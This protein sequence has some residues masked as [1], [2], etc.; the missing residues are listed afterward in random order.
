MSLAQKGA[1]KPSVENNFPYDF[2]AALHRGDDESALAC[3]R[4]EALPD[5]DVP[6]PR[7]AALM[8]SGEWDSNQKL[9]LVLVESNACSGKVGN[10]DY[11]FCGK[12]ANFCNVAAHVKNSVGP[13][14]RG[15]YISFGRAHGV[16]SS[17]YLPSLDN[18]GPISGILAARLLSSEN[19]FRLTKG[20]WKFVIDSWHAGRVES[21]SVSTNAE[22][23]IVF[24]EHT[25]PKLIDPQPRTSE[26]L[27]TLPSL[28][29]DEELF[30]QT[31]AD[32][33]LDD[34][35]FE[36]VHQ[37]EINEVPALQLTLQIE[38]LLTKQTEQDAKIRALVSQNAYFHQQR[39]AANDQVI[40][41]NAQIEQMRHQ[42]EQQASMSAGILRNLRER[43]VILEAT[44]DRLSPTGAN[45]AENSD[46]PVN[47]AVLDKIEQLD[48]AVFGT[49][50]TFERFKESFI[51]FREKLE[52]GGGVECNGISFTCHRDFMN[53]YAL[54]EPYVDIFLDALAYMHAIRAPVVH[55]DDATKLR[56]L[57]GKAEIATGLEA[58]VLTSFDTILPSILVGSGGRKGDSTLG[59]TYDWLSG[60]LKSYKIWKP[61]G[62]NNGVSHQIT[63]GVNNV[64]KRIAE[65][66]KR[67]MVSEVS[68]LSNGLCQSSANFCNELVRFVNEQQE[69]L[70]SNTAYSED[71]IWVMQLECIQRIVEELSEAR[72]AYSDAGRES[73]GNYIWGMLMSYKVQQR[74]MDNHFKD[75]PALTGVLVRRI[76]LQG[77]DSS[78]KKQLAKI[79]TTASNLESYKQNNNGEIRKLKDELAKLKDELSKLKK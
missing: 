48:S 61:V 41:V 51:E 13:I 25:Q 33:P 30:L 5:G 79:D 56:E 8:Q 60:Y 31:N 9:S 74:Y 42:S 4:S 68:L 50:G 7:A 17:P 47:Q 38:E 58:A 62:S 43:F 52:S 64:S 12:P 27:H 3:L 34:R 67:K 63:T 49:G 28:T 39:N 1:S 22:Q 35:P 19:P 40:A 65:L 71:Q 46:I 75:D 23:E 66:R 20:Q 15:W 29:T 21:L 16:L 76:L 18:G 32:Q 54:H 14:Q 36:T 59:G 6:S 57:Q 53:W 72:E 55:S 2:F 26:K 24:E 73:R 45:T 69:E 44:V 37:D 77:Q 11:R 10:D 70:T 78:V